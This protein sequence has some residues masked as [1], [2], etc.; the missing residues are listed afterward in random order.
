VSERELPVKKTI[1]WGTLGCGDVCE[2]KSGPPLYQTEGSRLVAVMRRDLEKA[3]DFARRHGVPRAC[4]TVRELVGDPQVDAVYVASP[5][6]CHRD[7][8][9]AAAHAGKHVLC[10]KDM[11]LNVAECDAMIAA[12]AEAGVTL[13]VAFYRRCYP[14]VLRA[15]ALVDS[16]EWGAVR[17]MEI[18]DEFPL[19]HRLDLFHFFLGDLARVRA[20][21]EDLPPG[22]HAPR[23]K[24]VHLQA[25]SGA[26]AVTNHGWKEVLAPEVVRIECEA[27]TVT[28]ADLKKG[29]LELT[30]DGRA[31]RED[32]GPE[33][34]TH[35]GLV[36]NFVD[37][38]NGRA[39][40]AC[41]GAEGRKSQLIQDVAD[42][43]PGDGEWRPV[44]Y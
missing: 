38:L 1:C 19:S 18:N 2:R 16:G 37:F 3:R 28:V 30:R 11:A 10:E 24:R 44:V 22:S 20:V 13:G 9:V 23:G 17:R 5:P 21:E 32:F 35:S 42:A 15:K 43:L 29:V 27:G 25:R 26:D 6:A 39:P 41:D 14:V 8:T 40:L 31:G 36:R 34:W 4:G 7:H 12:C 33:R